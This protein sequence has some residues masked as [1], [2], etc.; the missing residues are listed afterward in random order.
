MYMRVPLM[1]VKKELQG[2]RMAIQLALMMVEYSRRNAVAVFGTTRAEF[3]WI[4]ENNH[5]MVAIAKALGSKI[6]RVY[7]IY[8]KAL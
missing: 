3:G 5:G 6:N 4:L 2:G 8:E 1:G 7:T